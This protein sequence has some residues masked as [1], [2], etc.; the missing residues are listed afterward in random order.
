MHTCNICN[1]F[2]IYNSD[3]KKHLQTKKHINNEAYQ[4]TNQLDHLSNV[5]Y[6]SDIQLIRK[7]F[8]IERL[9]NELDKKD[10]ENKNLQLQIQLNTLNSHNVS[11]GNYNNNN[12]IN[13]INNIK[14]I[15]NIKKV[16]KIE[17]LNINFSDVIDINTYT[18]NYKNGYGLN[19]QQTETLLSNFTNVGI[20]SCIKTLVYYLKLS[21]IKQYKELKGKIISI[22]NIILP[23]VLLDKCLRSHFEKSK[24]GCWWT[25]TLL[26][27]IRKLISI[28]NDHIYKH[29]STYM[30]MSD[31]QKKKLENGI[32]KESNYSK[33]NDVAHL[34][35]YNSMTIANIVSEEDNDEEDD[36]DNDEEDDEDNDEE[37][38]EDNEDED[39]E[40]EDNEDDDNEDD[41]DE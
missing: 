34:N 33:L 28:T 8:E 15:K 20:N 41:E 26:E 11:N 7:E 9:K 36:E 12:V 35:L 24:R 14:N 3:F 27:N 40:D 32:L 5:N 37:E 19:F 2:T 39:N 22:E 6:N 4:N 30:L 21:A 10:L 1:Y 17:F 38:D 31:A 29:H 18:E 23:F 25:T 13:N 16:S